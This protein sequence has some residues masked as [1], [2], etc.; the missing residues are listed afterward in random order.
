MVVRN[1][2]AR[3]SETKTLKSCDVLIDVNTHFTKSVPKIAE[4]AELV[5]EGITNMEALRYFDWPDKLSY[6][7]GGRR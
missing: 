1:R 4:I 5:R 3:H 7:R 2:I 6:A